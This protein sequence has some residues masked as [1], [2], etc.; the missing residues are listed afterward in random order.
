MRRALTLVLAV[1]G[2]SGEVPDAGHPVVASE[3]ELRPLDSGPVVSFARL[4]KVNGATVGT[5]IDPK[6]DKARDP[7]PRDGKSYL[8][9][10]AK[11]DD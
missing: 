8:K 11:E 10:W 6:S 4:Q 7:F 5:G 9:K 3:L 2:C 1:L